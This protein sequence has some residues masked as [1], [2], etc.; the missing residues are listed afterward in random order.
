MASGKEGSLKRKADPSAAAGMTTKEENEKKE[1][2]RSL[3]SIRIE[4]EWV[5]DDKW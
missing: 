2:S 4:R 3:T 1:K 5:R